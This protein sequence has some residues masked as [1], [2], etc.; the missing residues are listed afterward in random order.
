MT[1]AFIIH[2]ELDDA[3]ST[4]ELTLIADQLGD[5]VEDAGFI[6]AGAKPW[7]TPGEGD[8]ALGAAIGGL[9]L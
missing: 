7:A 6:V 4:D 9:P 8:A 5:A 2:V 3:T 1:R